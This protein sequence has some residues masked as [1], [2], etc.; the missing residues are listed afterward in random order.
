MAILY[1][2]R[3]IMFLI[4]LVIGGAANAENGLVRA[5]DTLNSRIAEV[6]NC[7]DITVIGLFPP[8]AEDLPISEGAADSLYEG[9]ITALLE[10]APACTRYVDGR[11]AF[12][13]LDYLARAGRFRESGQQQRATIQRVLSEAD[14][15]VDSRVIVMPDGNMT[16]ALRATDMRNGA[17]VARASIAVPETLQ[18]EPCGVAAL[19]LTSALELIG[20]RLADRASDLTRLIVGGAYFGSGDGQTELGAYLQHE[21]VTVLSQAVDDPITDR[22]LSVHLMSE[23]AGS[24]S[25]MSGMQRVPMSA[26]QMA[27]ALSLPEGIDPD[28]S[29]L[30]HLHLRY[31][32]CEDED[33]AQLSA[34]L[35]RPDGVDVSE[36][37]ALRLDAVRADLERRPHGAHGEGRWGQVGR[38]AFEMSTVAGEN[39]VLRPGDLLQVALWTSLDAWIYCYYTDNEGTTYQILP[40][41]VLTASPPNFF[42]GETAHVFPDPIRDRRLRLQIDAS[43]VGQ[44]VITCFAT[45]RDVAMDLP[46]D[47]RGVTGAPV[48]AGVASRLFAAFERLTDTQV[49]VRSSTVTVME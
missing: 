40:H 24:G 37:V 14:I 33:R 26:E 17:A 28:E 29:G 2:I 31:W 8:D 4:A 32:L 36:V 11:G 44:E 23:A 30:Y 22:R 19:P 12:V 48:P 46:R 5:A 16:L 18:G 21:L 13:T 1:N 7:P 42:D 35:R 39:P 15:A 45:T 43:T 20:T 49:A 25:R 3:N 9:V 27:N 41:P 38:F 34:V 47:L 10:T 6:T